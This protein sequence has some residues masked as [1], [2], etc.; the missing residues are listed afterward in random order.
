MK[1]PLFGFW[2]RGRHIP[3]TFRD[4]TLGAQFEPFVSRDLNCRICFACR[5]W[6]REPRFLDRCYPVCRPWRRGRLPLARPRPW[7]LHGANAPDAVRRKFD[8]AAKR[9]WLP[10]NP[11]ERYQM[12]IEDAKRLGEI[13]R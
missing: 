3:K 10:E 8:L 11:L 12:A 2:Y 13:G 9:R 7:T 4:D 6:L 5:P 1:G